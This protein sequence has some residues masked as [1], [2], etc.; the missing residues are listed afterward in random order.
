[1]IADRGGFGFTALFAREGGREREAERDPS[2]RELALVRR[3]QRPLHDS[4]ALARA[5]VEV[6]GE[7]E[8]GERVGDVL[9]RLTD[10]LVQRKGGRERGAGA[11]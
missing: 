7:G 9:V 2:H 10:S 1:V 11:R 8:R 4:P 6:V 3:C 5:L